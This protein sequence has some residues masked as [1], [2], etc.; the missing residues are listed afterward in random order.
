MFINFFHLNFIFHHFPQQKYM[1]ETFSKRITYQNFFPTKNIIL[2]LSHMK[3]NLAGY[4]I[5]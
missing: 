4:K 1:S 3:D 2:L 5:V